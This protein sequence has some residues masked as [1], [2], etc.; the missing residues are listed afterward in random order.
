ME[1]L[2]FPTKFRSHSR[3]DGRLRSTA[4]DYY[5]KRF[6]GEFG[7][8]KLGVLEQSPKRFE[9]W[10]DSLDFTTG[11]EGRRVTQ[12][13]SPASW[14][15]YYEVGRRIFNWAVAQG[16]AKANPFL[17]F[18]KRPERNKRETRI[19]A[20]Q[21]KALF[22]AL[23]KLWRKRQR[24]EMKRRLIGAIDLGLREGEM[25]KVQ[26]K[27]VDYQT[28]RVT[29]PPENTKG[30]ASTDRAEAVYAMTPRVQKVLEER[31]SLGAD[32][33]VFGSESGAYVASFDKG[34]RELFKHAGLP[35][36]RKGGLIWHDLRHEFVSHLVDEGGAIHEVKEAARHKDI[37]TTERYMTAKEERLKAVMAKMATRAVFSVR[38]LPLSQAP[39]GR[40]GQ[41]E[42]GLRKNSRDAPRTVVVPSL[43]SP[44]NSPD[45]CSLS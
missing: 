18:S 6:R 1:P 20:G 42:K 45:T 3:E 25:L 5:L 44:A 43:R 30:G 16:F 38:P 40:V 7:S 23:P 9:G 12:K 15:R 4:L 17:K 32:R 10:L 8:E 35:V 24:T 27:H 26:V 34:W 11:R 36:G 28:W 31:R 39:R 14:N 33:F 21:E 37:R 41:I 2:Q 22:E 29:L 13:L 19:S